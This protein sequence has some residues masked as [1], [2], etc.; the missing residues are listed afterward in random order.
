MPLK[1]G[2]SQ[3]TISQNIATERRAGRPEKQAVAIAESEARRT[4]K[5]A[6]LGKGSAPS[7]GTGRKPEGASAHHEMGRTKPTFE[8]ARHEK[9]ERGRK[10]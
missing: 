5:D 6:E 9:L 3:K 8:E 1:R 7:K 2:S 4:Y 10:S